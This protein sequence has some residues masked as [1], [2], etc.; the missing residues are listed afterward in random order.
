[1][2]GLCRS[3]CPKYTNQ[4]W[5]RAVWVLCLF[6]AYL[7]PALPL[8]WILIAHKY[9]LAVS[10][11]NISMSLLGI[12]PP[13]VICLT[14][15]SRLVRE[16]IVVLLHALCPKQRILFFARKQGA[17]LQIAFCIIEALT[18]SQSSMQGHVLT[19]LSI[20]PPSAPIL[21][22]CFQKILWHVR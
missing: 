20:S 6:G 12:R 17:R 21:S 8:T 2:L 22:E 16:F 10:I 19:I 13:C 18:L 5:L 15:S 3:D 4:D 11:I 14:L 9:H 7:S 1:M